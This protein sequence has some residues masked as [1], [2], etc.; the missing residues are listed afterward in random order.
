MLNTLNYSTLSAQSTLG[1]GRHLLRFLKFSS[2][3]HLQCRMTLELTFEKFHQCS[4][5][6]RCMSYLSQLHQ[7]FRSS[8]HGNDPSQQHRSRRTPRCQILGDLSLCTPLPLTDRSRLF[9]CCIS[10]QGLVYRL[11][12]CFLWGILARRC[13][14]YKV[15]TF[16]RRAS[17][18]T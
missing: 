9:C 11:R 4:S 13:Q 16:A 1:A 10:N 8:A 3:I 17:E 15:N 18:S 5:M 12:P 7:G 6:A 14:K 2:L